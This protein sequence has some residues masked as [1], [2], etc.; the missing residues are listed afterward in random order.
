MY[1]LF[2]FHLTSSYERVGE[3]FYQRWSYDATHPTGNQGQGW[4][5]DPFWSCEES[6]EGL[7]I[8]EGHF[9]DLLQIYWMKNKMEIQVERDNNFLQS[10][11]GHLI[12][13]QVG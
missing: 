6:E 9:I 8:T 11:D 1:M 4:D 2:S 5:F 3:I 7:Q 10:A 12:I 13:V